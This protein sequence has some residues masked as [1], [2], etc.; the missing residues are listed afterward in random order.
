MANK[1]A[2]VVKGS[3]IIQF[4]RNQ[5]NAHTNALGAANNYS[6][7]LSRVSLMLILP[8]YE[9]LVII[10][11]TVRKYYNTL[12]IKISEGF[13]LLQTCKINTVLY[14]VCFPP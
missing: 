11:Q 5:K 9:P 10:N 4:N 1:R 6:L 3:E 7:F 14:N 12:F 13:V 2:S 8:Y